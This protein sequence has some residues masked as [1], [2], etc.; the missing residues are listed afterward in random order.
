ML[1]GLLTHIIEPDIY[2]AQERNLESFVQVGYD[3]LDTGDNGISGEPDPVK[4]RKIA[5]KLASAFST[6]NLKAKEATVN[7][8]IDLFVNNMKS[9]GAGK[10]GVDMRSWSDWLALDLSAD[11]TYGG[12]MGQMRDSKFRTMRAHA[13]YAKNQYS[14]G[15]YS[16]QHYPKAESVFGSKPTDKEISLVHCSPISDDTAI[17]LVCTA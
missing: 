6:R 3:A 5:K 16:A 14:E 13:Q 4:H 1:S 7:K 12:D 9:L 17:G 8:H 2:L 15:F 11:M 10:Q